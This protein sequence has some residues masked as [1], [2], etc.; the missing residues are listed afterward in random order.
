[1]SDARKPWH[2]IRNFWTL[3]PCIRQILTALLFMFSTGYVHRDTSTGNILVAYADG[4]VVCKLSDLE[5]AK[6]VNTSPT[7]PPDAKTVSTPSFMVIEVERRAY[8]F[9][10]HLPEL[11][12]LALTKNELISTPDPLPF[13]Y[14]FL[15]DIESL[16][17]TKLL[18]PSIC[19]SIVNSSRLTA[20]SKSA[21]HARGFSRVNHR[22]NE[23]LRQL[24]PEPMFRFFALAVLAAKGLADEYTRVE[25]TVATSS[26]AKGFTAALNRE[27]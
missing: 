21:P 12:L 26:V 14:N 11:N 23:G 16:L 5:Y 17:W 9:M 24:T 25:R 20:A 6:K 19:G 7:Q 13:R 2:E 1:M 4:K 3:L 10:P 22:I 15:H 18:P 27:I 8:R